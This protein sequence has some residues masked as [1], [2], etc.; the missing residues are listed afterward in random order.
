MYE[1]SLPGSGIGKITHDLSVDNCYFT[2]LPAA[3][4][5]CVKSYQFS[6]HPLMAVYTIF[7]FLTVHTVLYVT[8]V[9]FAHSH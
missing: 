3:L 2:N 4:G 8:H 5:S 1:N 7:F 9:R 6:P